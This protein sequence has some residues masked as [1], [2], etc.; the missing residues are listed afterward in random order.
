MV[1]KLFFWIALEVLV[2]IDAFV[3][4]TFFGQITVCKLSTIKSRVTDPVFSNPGLCN[5]NRL[6]SLNIIKM[7]SF[8]V[9]YFWVR[10]S[11]DVLKP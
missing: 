1:H 2:T 9:S 8:L 5:F 4:K 10:S 3:L 6:N 7:S 11:V